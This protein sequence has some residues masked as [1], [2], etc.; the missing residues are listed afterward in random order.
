MKRI[1]SGLSPLI[2]VNRKVSTPLHRQIY[3]AYRTTIVDGRLRPGQQL[4]STRALTSELKISPIPLLT[5]YAQLLAEG[6]LETRTGAG[7]FVCSSLPDQITRSERG[8]QRSVPVR[9][10]ARPV[11]RRILRVPRNEVPPWLG[12]GPFSMSQ[13]A[14]DEFPFQI[15]SSLVM[16]HSR[17][18]KK[19][20]KIP[21]VEGQTS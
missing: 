6:Y 8:G 4:P 17:R 11:A 10:E 16:C 2:A 19:Q 14:C 7:T 9:T 18:L 1:S 15:W 5:A 21:A 3:D 20:L 13:G 12:T